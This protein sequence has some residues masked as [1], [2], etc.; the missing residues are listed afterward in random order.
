MMKTEHLIC[1]TCRTPFSCTKVHRVRRGHKCAACYLS[2]LSQWK[3]AHLEQTR[4]TRKIWTANP[5]NRQAIR[6]K[7]MRRYYRLSAWMDEQ[8]AAP[9]LDCGV[10]YPPHVMDFD[11]VRGVKISN[12]SVMLARDATKK[13]AADEIAKCELVCSNCHRV[14]THR[15]KEAKKTNV[16]THSIQSAFCTAGNF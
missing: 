13:R 8:K 15:R 10:S 9:C 14:R 16:G 2:R 4:A 12:V 6:A 3:K 11:H 5:A 1:K 7:N